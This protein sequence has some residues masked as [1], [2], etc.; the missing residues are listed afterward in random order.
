VH[1]PAPKIITNE[2][3]HFFLKFYNEMKEEAQGFPTACGM[4]VDR[5]SSSSKGA[6]GLGK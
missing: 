6:G 5:V 3:L 1:H 2:V 4:E